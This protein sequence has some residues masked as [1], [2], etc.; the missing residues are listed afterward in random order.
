VREGVHK[1]LV[2]SPLLIII[3][4]EAL[5]NSFKQGLPWE[6]LYANDLVLVVESEEKWKKGIEAKGLRVSMGKTK[7][8]RWEVNSGQV[9]ESGEHPCRICRL[10]VGRHCIKCTDCVK[11]IYY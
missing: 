6:L 4:I 7:V 9:E 8:M 3:V 11:W 1:G 2:L 10:G 5:L